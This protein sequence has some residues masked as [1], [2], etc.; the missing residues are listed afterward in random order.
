ML[1]GLEWLLIS[2]AV[3]VIVCLVGCFIAASKNSQVAC[4]FATLWVLSE[5]ALIAFSIGLSNAKDNVEKHYIDYLELQIRVAQY[6]DLDVLEQYKVHD[7]VMTYNLWYERN[8][9]DLEN[10]WSFKGSSYY[11]KEFDYIVIGGK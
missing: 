8:K 5:V 11:A 2:L 7:D 6:D 3:I 1:V 4:V 9:S 10:E